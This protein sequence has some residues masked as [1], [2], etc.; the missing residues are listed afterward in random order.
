VPRLESIR[1]ATTDALDRT[2]SITA[3]AMGKFVLLVFYVLCS[4]SNPNWTCRGLIR[5]MPR[6]DT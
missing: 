6:L 4:L 1:L 5:P 3:I 2:K